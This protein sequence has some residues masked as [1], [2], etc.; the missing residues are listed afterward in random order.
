MATETDLGT[1]LGTYSTE[2]ARRGRLAV[3][4][5]L[6]GAAVSAAGVAFWVAVDDGAG[7]LAGTA[8]D[9]LLLPSAV[10]GLGFG[11]LILGAAFG[12]W[13]LNRRG[14]VFELYDNGLRCTRAGRP[15][16]VTWAEVERVDVRRGKDTALARWAGADLGYTIHC[17]GNR[18]ITVTGLTRDA[19]GLLRHVEAAT[20]R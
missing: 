8:G 9:P 10:L 7:R 15:V 13:F 17:A 3:V 19:R 16:S 5:L 20:G 2:N 14:E 11:L 1:V 18:K 12:I 6:A 4:L